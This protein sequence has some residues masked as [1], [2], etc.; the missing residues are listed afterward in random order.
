MTK[1]NNSA[2]L[3]DPVVTEIVRNAVVAITEEMKSNLMR[4]AYNMIIY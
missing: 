1:L 2:N 4:T 3:P